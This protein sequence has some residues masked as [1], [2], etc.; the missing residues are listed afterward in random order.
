LGSLLAH[1]IELP[2]RLRVRALRAYGGSYMFIDEEKARS[3]QEEALALARELG[4]EHATAS[5][6]LPL[7]ELALIRDDMSEARRFADEI[8]ALNRRVGSPRLEAQALA[9]LASVARRGGDIDD[10]AALLERSLVLARETGFRWWEMMT[11]LELASLERARARSADAEARALE[12]L[13]LA[14]EIHDTIGTTAALANLARLARDCGDV[15]RA[16]RLWGAVEAS[17]AARPEIEWAVDRAAW[18]KDVIAGGG[19]DFGT[20]RK[21]GRTLSLDQAAAYA[22]R[23]NP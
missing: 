10:A 11:L 15:E 3:L 13:E 6:L 2:A 20:A 23:S 22:L 1:D 18:E 4:D 16:G 17:D 8:L 19:L 21:Q 9:L 14:R 12:A 7:A 5:L